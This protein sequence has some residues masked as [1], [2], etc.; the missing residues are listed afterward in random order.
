MQVHEFMHWLHKK[1]ILTTVTVLVSA[2]TN[3]VY[4]LIEENISV[5]TSHAK[6]PVGKSF[7]KCQHFSRNN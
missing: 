6:I 5:Y 1:L 7:F 3:F 2:L 4:V